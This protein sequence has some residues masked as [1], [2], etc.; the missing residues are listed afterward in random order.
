MF[1]D[2]SEMGVVPGKKICKLQ[3]QN[4]FL[5]HCLLDLVRPSLSPRLLHSFAL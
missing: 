5:F 1:S 2:Y 3:K 4:T